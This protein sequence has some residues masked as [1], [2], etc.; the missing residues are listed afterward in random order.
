MP[1][2]LR[3][4]L[5]ALLLAAAAA[6]VAASQSGELGEF[7]AQRPRWSPCDF[8]AEVSCASIEVPL[9]YGNP[10]GRRISIAVSRQAADPATRRGVLF[11]N[12]GGPGGSGLLTVSS[13]GELV[14]W[15]KDRFAGTPLSRHY[16]LIGFDPRGVGRSTP[17]SC[18][19]PAVTRPLTSRPDEADFAATAEWARQA[20]AGCEQVSGDLVPHINT[21][22]TARDMDVL[23]AVLGEERISYVGYSYGTYLGA[24]YGT[25]FPRHL[26]RSVLDSAVPGD[27][28]WRRTQMAGAVAAKRNVEQWAAWA[29]DRP[30]GLGASQAE[31]LGV[32]E[33]VSAALPETPERF[34]SQRS[35]FDREVGY[36]AT[37]RPDWDDLAALVR[38]TR[39]TGA[40]PEPVPPVEGT[41]LVSGYVPVNQ[42]VHCE[43]D[44]PAELDVYRRDTA[45]FS[46]E[47]PY[48]PGAA[49]AMPDPCTFRATP[50]KETAT[51]LA[52]DGYPAGLVVQAEGD[53]QTEYSG[54]VEMARVLGHRLVT[55]A[56]DGDHGQFAR[57]GNTCVDDVVVRYLLGGELPAADVTCPG[58]PRPAVP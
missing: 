37:T 1:G 33:A 27:M 35:R 31:V 11:S 48:G 16:D 13:A 2:V 19:E 58:K 22:D 38:E 53:V 17:L 21:R 28:D 43:T 8:D 23:R 41:G 5:A 39:D 3:G 32:V 30:Y 52:R 49:T 15:P 9:D 40:F 54:G 57:R 18:E 20:Q 6:P 42:T 56:D 25:L 26:D 14:S 4:V 34:G 46:E 51:R 7:H 55:V 12:P 44:W 47:Y 29:A 50:P 24:V 10:G 45:R 36:L